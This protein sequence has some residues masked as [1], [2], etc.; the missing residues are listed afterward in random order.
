[1]AWVKYVYIDESGDLGQYGSRCFTLAAVIVDEPKKLSRIIKKLRQRKLKKSIKQLHE[2]KANN[3]NRMIRE[4]VLGK[5]KDA[6]CEIYAI[7]VQKEKIMDKLFTVKDRLYNYLCGILLTNLG[8]TQ[9]KL[10]IVIDKKHTNTLIRRDFDDYVSKKL[11][12]SARDLLIEITHK[13]S[14]TSNELQV[15]DFVAW[16]IE[17]NFHAGDDT[18]YNIIKDKISNREEMLIWK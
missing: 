1:M 14:H 10:V 12:E 8:I 9:G 16:C 13:L 18:Y 3:S 6:E 5:V 2:I 7:V 17:R 15:V 4:Y 11:K